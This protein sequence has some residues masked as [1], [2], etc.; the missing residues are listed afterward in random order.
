M[1]V[2]GLA[3]NVGCRNEGGNCL[4]AIIGLTGLGAGIGAGLGAAVDSLVHEVVY[5]HTFGA[6]KTITHGRG[7]RISMNVAPARASLGL[8]YAW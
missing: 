3:I 5:D 8:S 7:P 6:P 4:G 1:L 2:A